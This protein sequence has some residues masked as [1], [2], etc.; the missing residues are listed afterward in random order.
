MIN[1]YLDT[2]NYITSEDDPVG[3]DPQDDELLYIDPN[4]K[5]ISDNVNE[6]LETIRDSLIS[7]TVAVVPRETAKIYTLQD[8][9]L[10]TTWKLELVFDFIGLDAEGSFVLIEGNS[11]P[12][13]WEITGFD[14][15]DD[16]LF[17]E[18]EYD[19]P[20]YWGGALLTGTMSQDHNSI[21]N[22]KF[23]YWGPA[24]GTIYNLSGW[25]VNTKVE[26]GR[27]DMNPV[28]GSSTRYPEPVNP[29]DLLPVFDEWNGA[30]PSTV[31]HGLGDDATLG[32]IV[33]DMN[34][35]DW[36]LEFDLQPGGLFYLHE[37][38][39]WQ[40]DKTD[41]IWYADIWLEHQLIFEDPMSDT[42]EDVNNVNNV[43]I[44]R[45]YMGYDDEKLYGAIILHDY[46]NVS[47]GQAYYNL[48]LSYT[49]D[50]MDSLDSIKLEIQSSGATVWG[51]V[52]HMND[53]Y[54]YPYWDCMG[55]MSARMGQNG[56]DFSVP[57][58]SIPSHLPG[59][60]ISLNVS[61]SDSMWYNWNG[62]DNQTH[63]KIGEVGA[64]SGTVS[65]NAY[66]GAPIFVQAYTDP[67]APEDSLVASTMITAPGPYTLEGI[68]LGWEGHVR[69]FTPL[70]GFNVFDL[71]AL[72]I[73]DS[74][75]VFLWLENLD[76]VDLVL[77]NP[78]LLE[79]DVCVDGAIDPN[80][81]RDWYSFYAVQDGTYTLDVN[82]VTSQYAYMTLYGRDG[83]TELEELYYWQ[84][85]HIDW[86]CPESGR[87]YIRVAD[88]YWQPQGGTYRICMTS[89]VT[90][91]R[92]DI[93]APDWAGVEDCRVD[94]YD[95]AVL[96]SHWLDSCSAPYWCNES[97]FDESHSVNFVDFALL[98]NEWLRDGTP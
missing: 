73:Q 25:L 19:V 13:Q 24:Y 78:T 88:D 59:R 83:H 16:E 87:Y 67:R 52:C 42:W 10:A 57:W 3:T 4:D 91:P 81:D 1:Y 92:S 69:A 68:G 77:N 76:G 61:G 82:R 60:F 40:V 80:Y 18:M 22:G 96:I 51:Q 29:R 45:L 33:P 56:I 79:K 31:G 27:L 17:A 86:N 6:R 62:E 20:G 36:Q 85:Q 93:G 7:D 49:P 84:T 2:L 55:M 71:E 64:I 47:S 9:N 65:Y 66:S 75:P 26:E 5:D 35:Y 50:G 74:L 34:Q 95:L 97:D 43:D 39:P 30:Q 14:I 23:E 54:G 89:N 46:N 41:P 37:V 21:T 38:Y 48:Y 98:A 72:T 94:F 32:G 90:C 44:D 12:S 11:V 58:Y 63:L 15:E 70:F 28:F 8:A 53:S